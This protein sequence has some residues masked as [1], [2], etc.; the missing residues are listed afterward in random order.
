[1]GGSYR[2]LHRLLGLDHVHHGVD[3][4]QVGER[5]REVAEVSAPLRVD[6]L[7]VELE[8]ARVRQQLL[9]YLPGTAVLADA[10][11]DATY[12]FSAYLCDEDCGVVGRQNVSR[13]HAARW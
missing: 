12:Q 2:R 11:V 6:F 9:A 13:G 5:L 1:V 7:G 3:E 4:R 8:R 10:T